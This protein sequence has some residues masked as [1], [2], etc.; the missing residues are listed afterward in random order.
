MT[1]QI[2]KLLT[3]SNREDIILGLT[4][5]FHYLT[6]TEFEELILEVLYEE[7]PWGS[8][9]ILMYSNPRL[10]IFYRGRETKYRTHHTGIE[11]TKVPDESLLYLGYI[12]I[13]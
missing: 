4:L 11:E 9:R 7:S 2:E 1:P 10:Q 8:S 12:E 13:N 5:A 6:L 3:S